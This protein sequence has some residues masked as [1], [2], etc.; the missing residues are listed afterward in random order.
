MFFSDTFSAF[1]FWLQEQGRQG[2]A[3]MR[4][5]LGRMVMLLGRAMV[6]LEK[7]F[8]NLCLWNRV[9][10]TFLGHVWCRNTVDREGR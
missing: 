6:A 9:F 1:P 10:C 8:Y 5:I 3:A 4:E 7:T 2:K